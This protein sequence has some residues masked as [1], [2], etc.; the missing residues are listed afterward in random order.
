MEGVLTETH[1]ANLTRVDSFILTTY[2]NRSLIFNVNQDWAPPFRLKTLVLINCLV[3]LSFPV[4]LQVQ[5]HLS[6][7]IISNAGISDT[8]EEEWFDR[9]FSNSWYVDLSNN[10]INAKL[11]LEVHSE[12]LD[13]VDLSRNRFE[14]YNPLWLTNA[15]D[16]CGRLSSSI[17]KMKRLKFLSVGYNRLFEQLPD[18]WNRLRSLKL[19]DA[20][21]NSLSDLSNNNLIGSIPK[22]FHNFTA[23]K[24]GNATLDYEYLFEVQDNTIGEFP[25]GLCNLAFLDTSHSSKPLIIDAIESLELVLQQL[26]GKNPNRESAPD[27]Q[28]FIQLRR[29]SISLWVPLSTSCP[30]DTISPTTPYSRDGGDS[31]DKLFL[32]L[33]IAMGFI[34][35]FWGVCGTLVLKESWWHAYFRY[36]DEL[37]EKVLL[38]I[39]LFGLH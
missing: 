29:Q 23:L 36:V 8:I 39:A 13:V 35:G 26:I 14:G 16:I 27:A 25:I 28:R 20:S 7:V 32:Y 10:S 33:S 5:T 12:R 3:G 31:K 1:L 37:K 19:L 21:N 17:S 4:W 30:G 18:C 9:L 11:P 24:Y 6:Y 15:T 38:W 22:C 2:P 34:V